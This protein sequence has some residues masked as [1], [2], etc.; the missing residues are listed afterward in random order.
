MTEESSKRQNEKLVVLATF[1]NPSEAH[2]LRAELEANGIR[3]SVSNEN[4]ANVIG[5]SLFGRIAA[6]S[7]E[8]LVL[9]ADLNRAT[10]IKNNYLNNR[11][12]T[13]VPEWT[14]HCG[15]TV[16]AGFSTCWAC[17]VEYQEKN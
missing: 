7:I 4:S 2:R 13:P 16:D 14:C 9:D 5:A 10:E 12:E 3:A 6:I 1:D 8:V 15:E 11:K 17:G